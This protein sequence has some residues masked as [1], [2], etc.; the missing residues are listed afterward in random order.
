MKNRFYIFVKVVGI[1]YQDKNNVFG[2]CP[3]KPVACLLLKPQY[4][5]LKIISLLA[6]I[7]YNL[8]AYFIKELV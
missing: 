4:F 1:S 7:W 8:V 6:I 2:V 5:F 3:G